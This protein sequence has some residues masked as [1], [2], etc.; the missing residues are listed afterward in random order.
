[1]SLILQMDS[2]CKRIFS[3]NLE[4][5]RKIQKKKFFLLLIYLKESP[6][7]WTYFLTSENN[8]IIYILK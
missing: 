7:K 8:I 5:L 4:L 3:S 2:Y 6:I 1:M